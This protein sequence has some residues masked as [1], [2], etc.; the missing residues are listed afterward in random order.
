MFDGKDYVENK[1]EDGGNVLEFEKLEPSEF[2]IY[3][4]KEII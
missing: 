3:L 4:A 1:I 2:K